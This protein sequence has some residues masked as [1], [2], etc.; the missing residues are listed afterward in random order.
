MYDDQMF[1]TDRIKVARMIILA[2][3][4]CNKDETL[5]FLRGRSH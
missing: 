1:N 3:Y 2:M 4:Y 5:A